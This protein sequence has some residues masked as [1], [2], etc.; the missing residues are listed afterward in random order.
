MKPS[1]KSHIVEGEKIHH[2]PKQERVIIITICTHSV[3]KLPHAILLPICIGYCNKYVI[4]KPRQ[5]KN[6]FVICPGWSFFSKIAILP[7]KTTLDFK[8]LSLQIF[9]LMSFAPWFLPIEYEISYWLWFSQ[10]QECDP[11]SIIQMFFRFRWSWWNWFVWSYIF[12]IA[13]SSSWQDPELLRDIEAATGMDL[14]LKK[15]KG[16]K[17]GR[18]GKGKK[19]KKGA[20]KYPGLTDLTKRTNTSR[21]RLGKQVFNK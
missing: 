4:P 1:M 9:W 13:P 18:K 8:K 7:L 10:T 2:R 21:T 15:G 3:A 5:T 16:R 19:G 11:H 12:V 20:K 17:G 6:D 14:T